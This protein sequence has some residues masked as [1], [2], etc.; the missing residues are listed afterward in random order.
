MGAFCGGFLI[1]EEDDV[2]R[3]RGVCAAAGRRRMEDALRLKEGHAGAASAVGLHNV[4]GDACQIVGDVTYPH[5]APRRIKRQAP[6]FQDLRVVPPDILVVAGRLAHAQLADGLLDD[7]LAGV[8][9]IRRFRGLGGLLRLLFRLCGLLVPVQSCALDNGRIVL[10]RDVQIDAPVDARHTARAA[11]L[12][13]A[14]AVG[15]RRLAGPLRQPQ[16]EAFQ[17]VHVQH[18]LAPVGVAVE[19]RII[20][21]SFD[22]RAEG[23][24]HSGQHI[25]PQPCLFAILQ[26]VGDGVQD[27]ALIRGDLLHYPRRLSGG[28]LG[29]FCVAIEVDAHLY[30]R[31]QCALHVGLEIGVHFAVVALAAAIADADHGEHNAARLDFL[32]VDLALPYRHVDAFNVHAFLLTPPAGRS[33]RS[34]RAGGS[35]LL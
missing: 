20:A 33:P 32:P 7:L 12:P 5:S 1:L 3:Q 34:E 16:I 15:R 2:S 11:A 13:H 17:V 27:A 28:R 21:R 19:R 10:V 8:V 18:V 14:E 35:C 30:A 25:A 9:H 22:G 29:A 4:A 6:C 24:H 31:G 26:I 23:R